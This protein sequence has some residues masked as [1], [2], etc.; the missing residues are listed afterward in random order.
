M[1]TVWIIPAPNGEEKRFG[2]HPTQKPVMLLERIILALTREND[3][4]F[5]PFS[6]SSTTGVA[7]IKLRRK[8]IGCELENN[9]I[10]LSIKRL[11]QAISERRSSFEFMETAR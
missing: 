2:K 3:L 1:K 8:F 7:C 9:F 10:A 4:V 6:G 11:A 5:D